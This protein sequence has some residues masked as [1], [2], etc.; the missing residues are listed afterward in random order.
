MTLLG[1]V[2]TQAGAW[3]DRAGFCAVDALEQPAGTLDLDQRARLQ[4]LAAR[5]KLGHD[6]VASFADRYGA[7]P[8]Q[9]LEAHMRELVAVR[10][11]LSRYGL[12]DANATLRLGEFAGAELQRDYDRLL[13]QGSIGRAQALDVV[14]AVL[15]EAIF[16]LPEVAA[17][18]VR[19]VCFQLHAATLRQ[20]RLVQAWSGR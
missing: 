18:D 5:M 12:M 1:R 4:A 13:A 9:L 19:N 20:L 15:H 2:P 17:P 14:A 10:L 8:V 16:V 7:F 3:R 11:L 6:L